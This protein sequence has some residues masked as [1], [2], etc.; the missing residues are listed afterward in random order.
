MLAKSRL[1]S[2]STKGLG[3]DAATGG[4]SRGTCT[5]L[6]CAAIAAFA[7]AILLASELTH[8]RPEPRATCAKSCKGR[9]YAV[10][11][12]KVAATGTAGAGLAGAE[13]DAVA[14]AAAGTLTA[15][16][17]GAGVFA[18]NVGADCVGISFAI[19]VFNAESSGKAGAC[20]PFSVGSRRSRPK[21]SRLRRSLGSR[22]S[23]AT[24]ASAVPLFAS[25]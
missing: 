14:A 25:P 23:T 16:I 22:A 21:R 4:R 15:A 5:G 11:F 12:G 19:G 18:T 7:S 6:A 9:S 2:T 17:T 8:C 13:P 20:A 1:V 3:V 10:T 24:C